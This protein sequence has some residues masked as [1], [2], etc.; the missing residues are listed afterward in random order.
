MKRILEII[1]KNESTIGLFELKKETT[2]K[3]MDIF[4]N[5]NRDSWLRLS[6]DNKE[7]IKEFDYR[8]VVAF[9]LTSDPAKHLQTS[10]QTLLRNY[11][12][13]GYNFLEVECNED[14]Y[15]VLADECLIIYQKLSSNPVK[16][17][18]PAEALQKIKE[19]NEQYTNNH[20]FTPGLHESS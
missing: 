1:G 11:I 15:P 8:K 3:N 5:P 4:L 18:T 13:D 14:G 6:N 19:F 10:D 17:L 12:K 16:N 20:K 9:S 7:K 2:Y